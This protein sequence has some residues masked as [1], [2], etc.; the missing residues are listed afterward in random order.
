MYNAD[1]YI[2]I[3]YAHK[4]V[5]T[6]CGTENQLS[7]IIKTEMDFSCLV[8]NFSCLV[9]INTDLQKIIYVI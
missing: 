6:K 1:V 8:V 5:H 3:T 7:V 4:R 9:V 2:H